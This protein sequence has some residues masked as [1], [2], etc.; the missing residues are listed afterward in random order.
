[1]PSRDRASI[2]TDDGRALSLKEVRDAHRR[3]RASAEVP[4]GSDR[5]GL[6][7]GS[8]ALFRR[9]GY[10]ATSTTDLVRHLGVH[11]QTIYRLFGSKH[12]LY[13]ESVVRYRRAR[14]DAARRTLRSGGPLEAIRTLLHDCAAEAADPER[15]GCFIVSAAAERIPHDERTEREVH[16]FWNALEREL[17]AT[18][19]RAR[20]EGALS[21]GKDPG[22]I[23]GFLLTAMQGMMVQGKVQPDPTHLRN[24]ADAVLS[25][26]DGPQAT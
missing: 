18:L 1:M 2:S 8:I 20:G 25:L 13:V 12:G 9:R 7:E 24:I 19:E 10:A 21:A 22:A 3:A 17:T 26:L 4:H 5:H 14:F 23:A 16:W 6:L 11:R 15:L